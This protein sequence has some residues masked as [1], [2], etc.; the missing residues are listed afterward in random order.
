MPSRTSSMIDAEKEKS[1]PPR[2]IPQLL[3]TEDGGN[4][5][6]PSS[7]KEPTIRRSVSHTSYYP[8]QKQDDP[9]SPAYEKKQCAGIILVPRQRSYR[10]HSWICG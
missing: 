2:Q 6:K 1:R 10:R 7:A 4:E 5:K 8:Y 9:S 3:I